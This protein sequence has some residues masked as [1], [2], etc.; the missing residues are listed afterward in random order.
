MSLLNRNSN[1]EELLCLEREREGTGITVDT[2]SVTFQ[3]SFE[4]DREEK[5]GKVKRME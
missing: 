5:L 3:N 1:E 2:E 4:L